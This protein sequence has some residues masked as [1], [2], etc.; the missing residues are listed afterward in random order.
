MRVPAGGG[1]S[2]VCPSGLHG[3]GQFPGRVRVLQLRLGDFCEGLSAPSSILLLLLQCPPRQHPRASVPKGGSTGQL[4]Q[5]RGQ[6]WAWGGAGG[7]EDPGVWAQIP[8]PSDQETRPP[9]PPP[10]DPGVQAPDPSSLR[11]RSPGPR[12]LLPQTQES[13][14]PAP[15]PS[16]LGV[17]DPHP[18][19]L[20]Q[21]GPERWGGASTFIHVL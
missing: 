6:R 12:P 18:A 16:D 1:A 9:A 7:W 8:P 21:W 19:P 14:P 10:S 11:P 3:P 13:R 2:P 15:P 5:H 4:V 20:P 17:W